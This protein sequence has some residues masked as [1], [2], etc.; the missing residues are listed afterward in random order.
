MYNLV[1]ICIS[2]EVYTY[3]NKVVS[4]NRNFAVLNSISQSKLERPISSQF[5][6]ASSR[7]P[8]PPGQF[9]LPLQG[10][11]LDTNANADHH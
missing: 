9:H 4:T 8:S 1:S 10:H 7:I 11:F 5:P 6:D 3:R 2:L